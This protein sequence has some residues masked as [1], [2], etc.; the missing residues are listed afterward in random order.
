MPTIANPFVPGRAIDLSEQ[1]N[2]IPNQWGLF[3]QLGIFQNELKS[4]K[5]VMI[6]RI[7]ETEAIAV[8]RNWDERNSAITGGARDYLTLAIP[9]FPLDDHVT[10]NDVDGLIDFDALMS[11]GDTLEM[12]PRVMARKMERIRRTHALTLEFARA[13]VIRDG[14]VYAPRGTVNINYYTEFGVTRQ[15]VPMGLAS[16]TVDPL[17]NVN[18]AIALIQDGLQSGNI[19]DGFV[20]LCSPSFFNALITN[21]FVVESY[22]YF[23][24][25]QGTSILN[26]R[27]GT[28]MGLDAR[29]R[30]F[31]YGGV[32]FIEV[33]GNVNG[34]PYV[35]DGEAYMFPQSSDVFRTYFAPANRLDTVNTTAQEVYMY[36]YVD[37]KMGAIDLLSESN[38]LNAV[39]RPQAVITLDAELA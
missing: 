36:Q 14:S 17:Q 31:V 9:H 39:L 12:I 20:A 22:R 23:S 27:L 30:V 11:G 19:V 16:T 15:T 1:L 3:E 34:V 25:N 4:Q 24:Q 10:P 7:T 35:A 2:I 6:P 13:Q 37:Q 21:P 32:T 18:G 26:Q 29:Y 8:D 28:G 33:R 5:T 38:F